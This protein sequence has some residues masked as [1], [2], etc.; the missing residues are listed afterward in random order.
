MVSLG[1]AQWSRDRELDPQAGLPPPRQS[2]DSVALDTVLVRFPYADGARLDEVWQDVNES[3]FDIELR[4]RLDENGL[5][6]GI[7]IGELPQL[8]REQIE[9][10]SELQAKDALEHAGLAADVDSKMHRLRSRAGRRKELIVRRELSEPLTVIMKRDGEICGDTFEHPTVLFDLRTIPHG[11]RQ[12]TVE[13]TPEIQHGQLTQAFVTTEFGVRPESKRQQEI[14]RELKISTKL[15]PGDILMLSAT[16][17]PK[18][19]GAAFFTTETADKT[20]EHVIL[21]VRLAETQLDALFSPDEVEQAH[22]MTER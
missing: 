3:V 21:L 14:W 4:E 17:P 15:R 19:L 2:L 6:A 8:I 11:D 20:Q 12:A 10:T 18:A 9:L 13:L 7:L 22:A 1:C 5:R 16:F